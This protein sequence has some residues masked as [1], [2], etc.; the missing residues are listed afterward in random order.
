MTSNHVLFDFSMIYAKAGPGCHQLSNDWL[1]FVVFMK[2][3]L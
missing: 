2:S 1:M 3:M